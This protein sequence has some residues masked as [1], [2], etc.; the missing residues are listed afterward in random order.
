MRSLSLKQTLLAASVFA[1][2]VAA[3]GV[4]AAPRSVDPYSDGART[5]A[6]DP[7]TEGH[8]ADVRDP[9]TDGARTDARDARTDGA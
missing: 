8:R 1:T 6:R 4:Q 9:Y 7:Y 3:A 2:F 5:E